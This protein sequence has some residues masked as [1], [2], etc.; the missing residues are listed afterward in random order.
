LFLNRLETIHTQ[1]KISE[2]ETESSNENDEANNSNTNNANSN[3][4]NLN[5]PRNI[6]ISRK[7][8]SLSV[9]TPSYDNV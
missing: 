2:F 4:S 7:T 1:L 8:N 5:N 6:M 3:N 9:S